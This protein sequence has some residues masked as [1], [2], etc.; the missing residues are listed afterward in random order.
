MQPALDTGH[1]DAAWVAEPFISAA[2]KNG[3][4]IEY[5]FDAIARVFSSALGLRRRSGRTTTVMPS[6]VS[7]R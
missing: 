3:R 2:A 6:R 7:R 4:V 5:G 1:V